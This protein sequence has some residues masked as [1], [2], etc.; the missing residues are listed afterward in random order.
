M[1]GRALLDL[2]R[3][4]A[5][6][7]EKA[8]AV[9]TLK[10][11]LKAADSGTAAEAAR[12][13]GDLSYERG[14][15]EDAVRFYNRVIN[16]HQSSSHFGP[17]VVGTLWAHFSAGRYQAVLQTFSQ[18]KGALPVQDRVAA[19]YLAGSA[20]QE[21]G[22]HEEAAALLSK[23][24]HGDGKLD[25]QEKVLYKLA[26]S[27]FELGRFDAMRETI[28]SLSERYPE[29]D[30]LVEATYMLAAADAERGDVQRGAARL[31]ELIQAGQDHPYYRPA[32]L[33]RARLYE[34][35][36]EPAAAAQDY[37]QYVQASRAAGVS[38]EKVRQAALRQVN[39]RY[40]LGEYKP[41][42]QAARKLLSQDNLDKV[43]EQEAMY[44]LALSQ[45]KQGQHERALSSFQKLDQQHKLHPYRAESRYYRGLLHMSLG[46]G[47]QAVSLLEQAAKQKKLG[48]SLR[49]NALR[50][51]AL[52]QRQSD[53]DR[54]A[55]RRTLTRLEELVGREKLNVKERLWLGRDALSR[56]E[57]KQAVAYLKPLAEPS[58]KTTPEQRAEASFVLGK[59]HRALEQ[60]EAAGRAFQ[61]VE[62]MSRGFALEARLE[63]GRT[64][65]EQGELGAALDKYEG[66][67]S[68]DSS[69]I[70]A[71]ALYR[72][73]MVH[74]QMAAEARRAE[75]SGA[76]TEHNKAAR[77]LLKRMVLLYHYEQLQ[78]LPQLAYLE[79]AE[80]A[81]EMEKMDAAERELK[82]LIEKYP[83]GPYA[84]Y[85]R[86]ARAGYRQRY[87]EALSR[88][89]PLRQRDD[90]DAPLRER[91]KALYQMVEPRQ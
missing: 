33:R 13:A 72:S 12:L 41:A 2:A 65:A 39:L 36:D 38:N 9:E 52:R 58:E 59:A 1:R 61:R 15:Y 67:L 34:D 31:T 88:L 54:K 91:V 44:R 29:S 23:V 69:R 40:R 53:D 79:L 17:A 75:N 74:R 83:D 18:Y 43:T 6:Q 20:H 50:L 3:V 78:P 84:V 49:A 76:V 11:C 8:Q 80:I 21:Q 56:G 81:A 89:K 27:Q 48:D 60:Y 82:E 7:D 73:A 16:N 46:Q 30:R 51:L 57:P 62:A 37:G 55:A 71:R 42:E 25:I 22:N 28:K 63:W 66:L 19:W 77:K 90:L 26:V 5:L 47:E 35:H 4:R 87:G 14:Q 85:A 32:L 68:R 70:A 10:R 45:L 64:L 86:A 24:S